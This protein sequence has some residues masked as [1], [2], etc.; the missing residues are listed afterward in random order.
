[1]LN[2]KKTQLYKN[3]ESNIKAPYVAPVNLDKLFDLKKEY[4][5]NLDE[6]FKLQEKIDSNLYTNDKRLDFIEERKEI[7]HRNKWIENKLNNYNEN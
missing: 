6:Y 4:K 5:K 3:Y 7:A 2:L 1:M